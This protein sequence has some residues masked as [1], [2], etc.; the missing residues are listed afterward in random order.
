MKLLQLLLFGGIFMLTLT[1]AAQTYPMKTFRE[2][3]EPTNISTSDASPLLGDT[4][5]VKGVVATGPREIWI[6]ARWSFFLV[7]TGGGAWSALQI[8]QHDSF[9]TGTDAGI[10][11]P[12][13]SIIVT[14]IVEEFESA[15]Q[16]AILTNPVTPIDFLGAVTLPANFPQRPILLSMGD[17]QTVE[18]G[19]KYEEVLVRLENVVMLNNDLGGGEGLLSSRDGKFQISLEDW[20][21]ELHTCLAGGGDCEWPPRSWIFNVTGYIRD[22]QAGTPG[23]RFMISP[24]SLT[25]PYFEILAKAPLVENLSRDPA[26]PS[27]SDAVNVAARITDDV[28][29]TSAIVTYSVNE[30]AWQ[31]IFMSPVPSFP[32]SFSATIPSQLEGSLVKYFLQSSNDDEITAVIPGDTLNGPLFYFV[33][34]GDLSVQ[35]V[36]Q[37]PF[38]GPNS[39]YIDSEITLTGIVTSDSLQAYNYWIQNG[40]GPWSGILINDFANDPSPGDNVKVTGTIIESFGFTRMDDITSYE[41]L[42]TGNAIPEPRVFDIEM[43]NTG[44]DSGEAYEGVL[45]QLPN[46][47]VVDDFPD[48]GPFGEFTVGD[49]SIFPLPNT[50]SNV[51]WI[52]VD[53]LNRGFEIEDGVTYSNGDTIDI[54]RG[55]LYWSFSNYKLVPRDSNDVIGLRK[56]VSVRNEG[57]ALPEMYTL[58]QNYPNPFNPE[59]ELNYSLPIGGDVNLV[60]YNLLGQQIA[61]LVDEFQ[62]SGNY[63]AKWNGRNDLGRLLSS[64][65]Y[66]YRMNVDNGKFT[67]VKKMLL[68]K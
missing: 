32:D 8:V 18:S 60:I 28:G 46:V 62:P 1:A 40:N 43:I 15:T 56:I 51:N 25:E 31:D 54:I 47:V 13:D 14:G 63:T 39:G 45:L 4:V 67:D 48:S 64:G 52:R 21:N 37:N 33:R 3:Q 20:N 26:A 68:L 53:D 17:L 10:V 11:Q 44:S 61:T 49:T 2:V 27:S 5:R 29:I 36:Q 19:E 24:W 41:I 34:N 7:N 59:T 66:F 6:G 42:S 65:V 9:S 23:A 55:Y 16:L 38:G 58:S 57:G 22:K 12:G 35:D 50:S 30:A